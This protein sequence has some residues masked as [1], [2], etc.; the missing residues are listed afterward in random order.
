LSYQ[1]GNEDNDE[2]THC[3]A[4]NAFATIAERPVMNRTI[5]SLALI[6][7]SVIPAAGQA[8]P[9]S[10]IPVWPKSPPQWNAPDQEEHDTSGDGA[11]DV[12]GKRVIRL[13]F[14]SEPELHVYRPK[15][16][17]SD[18]VVLI[19]P[20][21]GYNIL[22]WDLEGTEI[23]QWL[24]GIGITA[25]VV[26]YRVP[27]G[28]ENEKWL[29]PVQDIQRSLSL[30]RSG[31]IEGL[32]AKHVGVLGF[33]AGG[34]AAARVAT[35]S[36]RHYDSMDKSD[37][38]NC[39][40]DFAVLV[41]PAWL[42]EADD[43]GKLID[44]LEITDQTPPMFFA[45]AIDDR[46]TCMSSVN[47]FSELKRHGI[48]A[49]LHVFSAGGHGFGARAVDSPTDAWPSLCEAWMKQQGWVE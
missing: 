5:F 4:I 10:V 44:G 15:G 11:R 39:S 26:K 6:A 47:L 19:C 3:P 14:V 41:Y 34:N 31:A 24:Q 9:D 36:K 45:H 13:G 20:G 2:S 16:A 40:P 7:L 23:A 21:G 38:A 27:T 42:V 46:V 29:A 28:G 33:S 22:A 43:D 37:E 8:K 17:A 30:V 1:G 12:A 48:P 25:V 18:T 35:T 32:D 49:S